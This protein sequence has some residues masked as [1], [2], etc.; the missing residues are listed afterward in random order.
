MD[1]SYI[2]TS[3]ATATR[4]ADT[5]TS[6]ATEVLDRANG[7]KPAFFTTEGLTIRCDCFFNDES[8][9]PSFVNNSGVTV[10]PSS[11]VYNRVF[12]FNNSSNN[13]I[14]YTFANNF[15]SYTNPRIPIF[16]VFGGTFYSQ[17]THPVD[18]DLH[19]VL[20]YQTNNSSLRIGNGSS[21]TNDTDMTA[22]KATRLI[23]GGAQSSNGTGSEMNGTIER[24]TIWKIPFDETESNPGPDS[25]L[26]KLA[27]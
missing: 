26:Q 11:H 17:Q 12:Q 27:S 21:R 15:A 1:T 18:F 25:K 10:Y 19:V 14:F 2:P 8:E 22:Q 20:R 7:T 5:F 24:L 13:L 23:I 6:T 9:A 3:G 4:A 16:A